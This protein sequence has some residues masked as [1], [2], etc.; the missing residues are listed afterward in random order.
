MQ[1]VKLHFIKHFVCKNNKYYSLVQTFELQN[2]IFIEKSPKDVGEI[3]HHIIQ[4]L[5]IV[6]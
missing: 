3:S 4:K 5:Q 1:Y 6:C 2:S